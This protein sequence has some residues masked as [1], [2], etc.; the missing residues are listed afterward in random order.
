MRSVTCWL[1]YYLFTCLSFERTQPDATYTCMFFC[2]LFAIA[3]AIRA[4]SLFCEQQ[5][6]AGLCAPKINIRYEPDVKSYLIV[7]S[8]DYSRLP[9]CTINVTSLLS[10][11]SIAVQ[12]CREQR[13]FS[14]GSLPVNT[15]IFGQLTGILTSNI[16]ASTLCSSSRTRSMRWMM[17]IQMM[18]N[19]Q[20]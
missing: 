20:L 4:G 16:S 7:A 14:A 6:K 5:T 2:I 10:P 17:T 9:I 18:T 11:T 1:D 12:V 19:Q 13:D 8:Y 15:G 3:E